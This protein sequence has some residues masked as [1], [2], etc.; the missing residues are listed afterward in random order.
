MQ[1]TSARWAIWPIS[2]L[3][4]FVSSTL[5]NAYAKD[6]ATALLDPK[7]YP[8]GIVI[9]CVISKNNPSNFP[10]LRNSFTINSEISFF[11]D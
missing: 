1:F 2:S 11:S 5:F 3:L 10:S 9:S 8:T 4:S 6:N 7:P